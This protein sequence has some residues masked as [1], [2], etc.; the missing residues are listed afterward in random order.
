MHLSRVVYQLSCDLLNNYTA[1]AF[2]RV[3]WSIVTWIALSD[4]VIARKTLVL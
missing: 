3:A 1:C 4:L 2:T